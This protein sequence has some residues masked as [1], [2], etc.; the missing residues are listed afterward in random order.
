MFLEFLLLSSYTGKLIYVLDMNVGMEKKFKGR[1][2]SWAAFFANESATSFPSTSEWPFSQEKKINLF[3]GKECRA[4]WI[5]ET[6]LSVESRAL[7][8]CRLEKLSDRM[9]EELKAECRAQFKASRMG[10]SSSW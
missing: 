7:S 3:T 1:L 2:S 8:A 4:C 5:S 10:R 6:K 9:M